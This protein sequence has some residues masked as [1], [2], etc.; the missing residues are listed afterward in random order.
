[1][2]EYGAILTILLVYCVSLQT[3]VAGLIYCT[4]FYYA[5][6]SRGLI[7]VISIVPM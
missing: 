4:T 7:N 1:M 5:A 3:E 2:H 6:R